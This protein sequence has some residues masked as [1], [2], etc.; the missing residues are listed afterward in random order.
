V[1]RQD[2]RPFSIDQDWDILKEYTRRQKSESVI[3]SIVDEMKDKVY[4]QL[5][6]L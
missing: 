6:G 3:A 4:L 5:R 1:D 2:E